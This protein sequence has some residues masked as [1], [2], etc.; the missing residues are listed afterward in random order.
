MSGA[1]YR[2]A[3]RI[4]VPLPPDEAFVLFTPRGEQ[5]WVDG[6]RPRFAV[7][8]EDDTA[9]GTV[10]ETLADGEHTIWLVLDR[11]PGR[12]MSYARVTPTSRA[13]T[14]SVALEDAGD[15]SSNV[16]VTYAMTALSPDGDRQLKEFA[17][18]YPDFLRSWESAIS[19]T[20]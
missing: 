12:R 1:Q 17:T 10:F 8:T 6:W 5:Q 11:E 7:P 18:G 3:G 2:L 13:G 19:G 20:I 4:T 16:A 14:V 9:P 15:G